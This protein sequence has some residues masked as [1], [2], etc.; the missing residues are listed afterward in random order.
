MTHPVK[1]HKHYLVEASKD[2]T[3]DRLSG[4]RLEDDGDLRSLTIYDELI[5]GYR[6]FYKNYNLDMSVLPSNSY[7]DISRNVNKIV[8]DLFQWRSKSALLSNTIC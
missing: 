5:E 4:K 7:E 1:V 2:S 3:I 8:A 6:S